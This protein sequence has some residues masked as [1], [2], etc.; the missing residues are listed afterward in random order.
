MRATRFER[1]TFN[2]GSGSPPQTSGDSAQLTEGGIA[3]SVYD[4]NGCALGSVV[5]CLA[6]VVRRDASG[7]QG[8]GGGCCVV[9]CVWLVWESRGC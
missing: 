9:E 8:D 4:S 7:R 1:A 2:L 3:R 5:G 6:A